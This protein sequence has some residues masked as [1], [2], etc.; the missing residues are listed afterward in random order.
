MAER[1]P[2]TGSERFRHWISRRRGSSTATEARRHGRQT[3]LPLL[4]AYNPY[5]IAVK[6]LTGGR[7]SLLAS[8][9][10]HDTIEPKIT[11][12]AT[13]TITNSIMS[14]IV[15]SALSLSASVGERPAGAL[16]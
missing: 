3:E 13:M 14:A 6:A 10:A 9:S 4:I 2:Q 1:A 16:V 5:C 8:R 11:R 12:R 7:L 15:V